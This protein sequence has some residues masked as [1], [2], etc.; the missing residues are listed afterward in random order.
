MQFKGTVS[1][2]FWV[3]FFFHQIVPSCPIRGTLQQ[4]WFFPNI[5]KVIWQKFGSAVYN[6]PW[7]S[8]S[9]VYHTPLNS[10]SAEFHTQWNDNSVVYLTPR[11]LCQKLFCYIQFFLT[12][13]K[14]IQNSKKLFISTTWRCFLHCRIHNQQCKIHREDHCLA[15]EANYSS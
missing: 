12:L 9:T 13:F 5:C 11:S 15:N 14:T 7:N 2:N 10:D 8:D 1:M 6:T 3:L 4:F